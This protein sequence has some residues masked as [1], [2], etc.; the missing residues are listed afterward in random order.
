MSGDNESFWLFPVLTSVRYVVMST[1][2][3]P[4]P[5]L[6]D[7][8]A[9]DAAAD[10]LLSTVKFNSHLSIGCR[11]SVDDA[12]GAAV[13]AAATVNVVRRFKCVSNELLLRAGDW[14]VSCPS[15]CI[16]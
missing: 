10:Q 11:S 7:Q 9:G 2:T 15:T 14:H 8:L 1:G 4:S 5:A 12:A 13:A 6:G 3:V 16:D